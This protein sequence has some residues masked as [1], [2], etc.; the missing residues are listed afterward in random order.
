[1]TALLFHAGGDPDRTADAVVA[2][3]ATD[4]ARHR[5]VDLGIAWLR[6]LSQQCAGRHD[7]SGLAVAALH[8]VDPEP[9]LLQP[10]TRLGAADVLDG[11]DLCLADAADRQLAGAQRGPIHVHGAGAAEPRAASVLGADQAELA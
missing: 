8:D 9:R 1:M 7:L 2:T 5:R 4:V 11:V 3:T 10:R 6:F